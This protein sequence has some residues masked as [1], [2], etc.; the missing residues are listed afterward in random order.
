MSL[1][2]LVS[3]V[4]LN[5]GAVSIWVAKHT[6]ADILAVKGVLEGNFATLE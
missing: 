2:Y 1:E 3:H 4:T 5:L 6:K